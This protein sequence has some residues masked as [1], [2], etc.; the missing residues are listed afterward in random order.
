MICLI[1]CFSYHVLGQVVLLASTASRHNMWC[2]WC[3]SPSVR[4]VFCDENVALSVMILCAV[5]VFVVLFCFPTIGGETVFCTL[6]GA[7]FSTLSVGKSQLS[8]FVVW[9]P[10][11]YRPNV[12][13]LTFAHRRPDKMGLLVAGVTGHE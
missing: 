7:T 11:I 12:S 4:G 13:K 6:G 3:N 1:D 9:R 2:W 8:I 5:L 10:R